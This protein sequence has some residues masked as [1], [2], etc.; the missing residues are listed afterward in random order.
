MFLGEEE[1]LAGRK[2]QEPGTDMRG[3]STASH[4]SI[5]T[6]LSVLPSDLQPNPWVV[7][8]GARSWTQ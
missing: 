4:G 3:A 1:P 6:A 8:R 2:D 7:L 5:G